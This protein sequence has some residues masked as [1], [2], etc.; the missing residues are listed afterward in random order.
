[1]LSLANKKTR[2]L[3]AL[4]IPMYFFIKY[5]YNDV[6]SGTRALILQPQGNKHE[7]SQW[8]NDDPVKR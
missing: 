1:M 7:E 5:R 8:V 3:L 2:L 4:L 6:L